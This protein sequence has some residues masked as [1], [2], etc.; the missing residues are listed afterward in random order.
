MISLTGISDFTIVGILS[1]DRFKDPL[2]LRNPSIDSVSH[3]RVDS[4]SV[5]QFEE[6]HWTST[7][8]NTDCALPTQH[9]LR[10]KVE[11]SVQNLKRQWRS[12]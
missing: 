8:H 12:N 1:V 5:P 9:R 10:T 3:V 4:Y 11:I 7:Q 6:A 2:L